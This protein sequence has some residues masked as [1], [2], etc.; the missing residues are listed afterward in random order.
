MCVYSSFPITE[1]LACCRFLRN[2]YPKLGVGE[3]LLWYE[4][5]HGVP[6]QDHSAFINV[7]MCKREPSQ[8]QPLSWFS[9]SEGLSLG[10]VVFLT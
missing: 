7:E 8:P 4:G 10:H 6:H 9:Y 1:D 5:G 2:W 3:S